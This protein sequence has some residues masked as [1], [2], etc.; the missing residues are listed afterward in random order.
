MKRKRAVLGYGALI[1]PGVISVLLFILSPDSQGEDHLSIRISGHES[2]PVEEHIS[3]KR[4]NTFMQKLLNPVGCFYHGKYVVGTHLIR[5]EGKLD[6]IRNGDQLII[7]A[8]RSTL[9]VELDV[10]GTKIRLDAVNVPEAPAGNA[11]APD[12]HCIIFTC[13]TKDRTIL[14]VSAEYACSR[15]EIRQCQYM[16]LM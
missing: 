12:D 13:E 11:L 16:K 1:I 6:K 3:V 9:P 4:D 8:N 10:N 2:A 15:E 7:F 14:P 5:G